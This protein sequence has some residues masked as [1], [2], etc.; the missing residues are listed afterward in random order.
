MGTW[1]SIQQDYL[2]RKAEEK[3]LGVDATR[4]KFEKELNKLSISEI[5]GV[6]SNIKIVIIKEKFDVIC[7]IYF[8]I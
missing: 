7:C 1:D 5:D 4:E 6:V 2:Y 8:G 3:R